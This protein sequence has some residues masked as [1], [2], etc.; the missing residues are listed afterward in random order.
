MQS[1]TAMMVIG[2]AGIA[3]VEYPRQ[4]PGGIVVDKI[5]G[6][7]HCMNDI[8]ANPSVL[9]ESAQSIN[10]FAQK[11]HSIDTVRKSLHDDFT[12]LLK[13]K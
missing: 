2:P 9:I 11:N 8:V 5:E 12:K 13:L 4:I 7:Q 3:S 10:D 1:G 6:I